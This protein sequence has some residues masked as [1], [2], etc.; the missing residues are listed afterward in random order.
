[1]CRLSPSDVLIKIVCVRA[2]IRLIVRVR[3]CVRVIMNIY[4]YIFVSKNIH[5]SKFEARIR[6]L[7]IS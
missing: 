4:I 1:M 7:E 3:V 2:F 5:S 6:I